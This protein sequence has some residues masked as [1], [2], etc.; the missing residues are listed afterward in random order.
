MSKS[1]RPK[2]TEKG[3]EEILSPILSDQSLE[4]VKKR[5]W[6]SEITLAR[7]SDLYGITFAPTAYIDPYDYVTV[8]ISND[9]QTMP[10]LYPKT[11]QFLLPGMELVSEHTQKPASKEPLS[12]LDLSLLSSLLVNTTHDVPPYTRILYANVITPGGEKILRIVPYTNYPLI[13]PSFEYA[14]PSTL[15]FDPRDVT[16]AFSRYKFVDPL[17]VVQNFYDKSIHLETQRSSTHRGF[18]Y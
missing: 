4:T 12:R 7:A 17:A 18:A 11:E 16:Y 8:T 1:K 5:S 9:I 15:R 6:A 14:H 13:L 3:D 2:H 10:F